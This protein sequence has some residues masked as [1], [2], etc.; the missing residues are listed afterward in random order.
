MKGT[1][2]RLRIVVGGLIGLLPAGGVAWDYVQYPVGLADLGHDVFYIEDTAV[3]PIFHAEGSGDAAF[4]I[5]YLGEVMQAFGLGERWAYRDIVDGAWHGPCASRI[6]DILATADVLINVSC[7]TYFREAY[8]RIP[9]R[10][11]IDS[12]PMFTQIQ[13]VGGAGLIPGEISMRAAIEGHSHHFTFGEAI[14]DPDCRIPDCGVVWR[15]TRQPVVLDRWAGAGPPPPSAAFTTVM[16]WSAGK[17]LS[18]AGETW[19]QKDVELMRLVDLPRRRPALDLQLA[20]APSK[21]AEAAPAML[22]SHGWRVV[23][24]A[25]AVGGWD[26]YRRYLQ[27]SLAEFSVAKETYVKAVTGWFSCR[28]ACYL[29]SGRA[30]VAQ[31]TGWSR[32]LPSGEGLFAFNTEEEALAALDAVAREPARHGAAAREIAARH[33]DART[34]LTDLLAGLGA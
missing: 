21:G 25:A 8:E 31:D 16:N 19:G 12:D 10:A 23:D 32:R 27:G 5:R 11:L 22:A 9:V 34:V 30:V 6:D 20:L 29:A 7:S 17:A 13:Y 1:R 14:G 15:P 2:D 18:Y 26:D 3:W 33:F 4:G 28:S 24:A